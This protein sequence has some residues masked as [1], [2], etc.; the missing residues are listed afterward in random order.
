MS[1]DCV[2][3]VTGRIVESKATG[4]GSYRNHVKPIGINSGERNVLGWF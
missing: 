3:D 1:L 4:H 2:S